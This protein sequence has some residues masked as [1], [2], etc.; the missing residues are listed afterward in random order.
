[1]KRKVDID[2]VG[3]APDLWEVRS[4]TCSCGYVDNKL[5]YLGDGDEWE[6]PNCHKKIRFI[7]VGLTYKEVD[8]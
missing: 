1:M 6:C 7:Y 3:V 5:R 8:E 4:I 2:M